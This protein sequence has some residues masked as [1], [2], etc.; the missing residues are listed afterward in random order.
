[1]INIFIVDSS[2]YIQSKIFRSI[3]LRNICKIILVMAVVTVSMSAATKIVKHKIKRGETLYTIAHK[4]K[5]TIKKMRKLNGMKQGDVLKVGKTVKVPTTVTK[6]VQRKKTRTARKKKSNRTLKTALYKHAQPLAK[7]SKK[8]RVASFDDIMFKSA[9]FNFGFS[10]KKSKKII[11]LAKQKLGRK[12]VWGAVGQQGTFDCSGLT[13]YVFAKNGIN[14]PRT[15]INQSKFGKYVSRNNLKKGD[16][17]FFDTSK[18]RKGY[19][20]HVGIYLG[21]GKFIHAS[22]AKKKVVITNLSKFYA[23]RY[24]GARRPS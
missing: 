12:Y 7:R 8:R 18:R 17:I 14:I 9:G 21:N 16:L 20:N 23:K 10:N 13:K 2:L 6:K 3:V 15:S 4:H 1:M 19:V 11:Q 22:S 5:T 24:K